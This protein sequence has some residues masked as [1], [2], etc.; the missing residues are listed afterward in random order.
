MTEQYLI[1]ELSLLL[2]QLQAAAGSQASAC[3][4][5]RL[6]REAETCPLAAL[7]SLVLRALRLADDLCWDSLARGD[8][9]AFTYQA[10]AGADLRRFAV[11]ASLL[12]DG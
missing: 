3:D 10:E 11:C 12:A 5:V 4:V 7:G 9:R 2:A 6:R 1:G 8:I